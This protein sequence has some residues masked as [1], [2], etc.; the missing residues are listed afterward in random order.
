GACGY[1]DLFQQGYGL[2]TTA[3]STALFNNGLTCGACFEITCVN[4]RQWCKPG[5][6][7]VTATNFCPPNNTK[8]KD[9]WCNPPQK[10]FDLTM[11]MFLK[12]AQYKAGIVPVKYRRVLCSKQGGVKFQ[13]G[14][15]P[16][17]TLVLLYNV[18]GAGDVN[19]VKIKATNFCPPNYTKTVDVW[20]N[21]PQKH[22]DLSLPM[23]LQIA[24]YKAGVVPVKYRRIPCHKQGGVKFQITGNPYWTLVLVYNVGGVGDVANV[25]IK[26]CN[27]DW[28]QM[29]RNWGQN[30]QT[31]TV[32]TGQSLSFRVALSDGNALEFDNVVPASWQFGQTYDGIR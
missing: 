22:F 13:I 27:T 6:I 7:K 20:C 24:Q 29:Y 9:V 16:Y 11:Q 17:F 21:P 15:N 14:G 31:Q 19:D 18:G 2:A 3:L 25:K 12:I 5:T 1:G 26:G 10:H 8:T 23:F 30:W 28:L 32:L 4:D